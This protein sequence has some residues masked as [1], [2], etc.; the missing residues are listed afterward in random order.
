LP[1]LDSLLF[2]ESVS[3][4]TLSKFIGLGYLETRG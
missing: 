4:R 3:V 2:G 1:P